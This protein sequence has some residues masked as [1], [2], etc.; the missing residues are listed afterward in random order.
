MFD[1]SK[2]NNYKAKYSKSIP[3]FTLDEN[4][5]IPGENVDAR[6]YSILEIKNVV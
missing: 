2:L 1:D 6:S 3:Y 4:P 5:I